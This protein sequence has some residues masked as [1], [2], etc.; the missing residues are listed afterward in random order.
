[1]RVFQEKQ[2]FNQWWVHLILTLPIIGGICYM[3]YTWYVLEKPVDK[4]GPAEYGEQLF[5]IALLIATALL[6]FI[7]KLCLE[8]DEKGIQ[9]QFFPIHLKPRKINWPAIESCR[10]IK[11]HPLTEAGGW[12]YKF[13]LDGRKIMSVKGNQGIQV[14]LKNGKKYLFG[15][16][17]TEE[18]QVVINK[19]FKDERI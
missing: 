7:F 9:Y 4:V 18:A 14:T 16:Q 5:V 17:K 15:T 2:W 12:G 3:C 1:M 13:G 19:Y 11:Y 6:I 10:T 8:I